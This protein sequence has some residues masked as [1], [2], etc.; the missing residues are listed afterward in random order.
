MGLLYAIFSIFITLF[1]PKQIT[2]VICYG[3]HRDRENIKSKKI[4]CLIY[5]FWTLFFGL[6]CLMMGSASGVNNTFDRVLDYYGLNFGEYDYFEAASIYDEHDYKHEGDFTLVYYIRKNE[7]N[8]DDL[9]KQIV[10]ENN[11][12]YKR[13]QLSEIDVLYETNGIYYICEKGEVIAKVVVENDGLLKKVSYQW[14]SKNVNIKIDI[15]SCFYRF[16]ILHNTQPV[17]LYIFTF[18]QRS[19]KAATAAS[20]SRSLYPLLCK[21]LYLFLE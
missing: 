7:D 19:S 9:I 11:S 5:V 2:D 21:L 13:Y 17:L 16:A 4:Y 14:S 8:L 3:R 1:F 6:F 18:R 12:I 20:L 10:Q 15:F